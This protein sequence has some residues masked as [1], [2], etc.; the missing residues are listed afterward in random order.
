VSERDRGQAD[1]INKGLRM[2]KGTILAYLNSDDLLYPDAVSIAVE[3]F[4]AHPGVEFIYGDGTVVDSGGEPLW[5]WLSRPED[6]RL[7]ADYF[8]LWNDF[9]NYILQPATFWLRPLQER[10]GLFDEQFHFA[11]DVEFWLRVGRSGARMLHVPRPLAKFRMEPGTKTT[12]SPTAFWPDHLELF[13]RYQGARKMKPYVEQYLFE[14]MV[15]HGVPMTDGLARFEGI[16]AERWAGLP[17]AEATSLRL[18]GAAAVPGALVRLA[19]H[20]WNQGDVREARRRLKEAVGAGV[21]SSIHPRALVLAAKLATG[22]LS[23][24]ARRAWFRGIEAYRNRR[25]QYRYRKAPSAPR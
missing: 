21:S 20:A 16:V 8:F 18:L 11:M 15:K 4:L 23:P 1:A 22:P 6:W 10:I 24:R 2:A 19:D 17:E 3:A 5:E 14:V 25:Y 13:R 7:L 9:T 12:S